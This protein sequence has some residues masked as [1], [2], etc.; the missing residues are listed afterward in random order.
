VVAADRAG[1]FARVFLDNAGFLPP[2]NYPEG[3]SVSLRPPRKKLPEKTETAVLFN[4][5]RRCALCFHLEG[6]FDEKEGQ[7]AHLDHNAANCAEDNLVFLC[8]MHHTRYDSKTSQ[9]KNYTQ[10]EVKQARD[11]L[12][13]WCIARAKSPAAPGFASGTQVLTAEEIDNKKTI[14]SPISTEIFHCVPLVDDPQPLRQTG[15]TELLPDVVLQFRGDPGKHRVADIWV[16]GNTNITSRLSADALTEANLSLATGQCVTRVPTLNRGI[17]AVQIAANAL[18][19][20]Q[21]PLHELLLLPAG[22]RKLRISN[23]R[24]N[25]A[26]L[27]GRTGPWQLCLYIKVS[28]TTVGPDPTFAVATTGGDIQV[29]VLPAVAGLNLGGLPQ[30]QSL[31]SDLFTGKRRADKLTAIVKVSGKI[32][33]YEPAGERTR[34]LLRFNN[35]AKGLLIF[36]TI[37]QISSV[38]TALKGLLTGPCDLQG[39]GPLQKPTIDGHVMVGGRSMGLSEV[40]NRDGTGVAAWEV[41]GGSNEEAQEMTFGVVVAYRSD[42][43]QNLPQFGIVT[44]NAS[45]APLST[46]NTASSASP[47][48]RFADNTVQ[49]PFFSIIP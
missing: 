38:P 30:S 10:G 49:I 7:L 41:Q 45:L 39:N 37:E 14:S 29:E 26:Q 13:E 27:D 47:I 11:N 22:E 19:F 18:A 42:P 28:D 35:I 20:L 6:D 25:P 48:P 43:S 44:L 40:A 9:H 46:V 2:Y 24:M 4:S 21:V 32:A 23:L 12:Y 15:I 8:L 36:T 17:R 1:R 3:R 33:P 16:T 5:A 34:L 31:N